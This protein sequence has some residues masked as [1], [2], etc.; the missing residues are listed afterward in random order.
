MTE[1]TSGDNELPAVVSLVGE[2]IPTEEDGVAWHGAEDETDRDA[3]EYAAVFEAN[4]EEATQSIATEGECREDLRLRG[5][6][7]ADTARDGD[8]GVLRETAHPEAAT[9]VQVDG[10]APDRAA[11]SAREPERP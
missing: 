10:D 6:S 4:A 5:G 2:G 3:G 8:A 11:G 7:A 9:I 1:C